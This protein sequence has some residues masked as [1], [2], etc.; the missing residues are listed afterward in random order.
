MREKI[1]FSLSEHT[2][3]SLKQNF[4]ENHSVTMSAV[5][6]IFTENRWTLKI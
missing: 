2:E 1:S 3:V 5:P 4:M 6:Y